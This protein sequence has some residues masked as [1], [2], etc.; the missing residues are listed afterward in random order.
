MDYFPTRPQLAYAWP[1]LAAITPYLVAER[2][3]ELIA[4]LKDAF[5]GTEQTRASTSDDTVPRAVAI[6][7]GAVEVSEASAANPSAPCAIH[8][9]VE[10]AD[11]VYARGL[12]A[13]AASIYEVADQP[14]G[15]RQGAVKDAWGNH[16]YIAKANW[17]PGSEGIS[18]VQ[19]F[20]HLHDAGGIIPFLVAA[21]DAEDLGTACSDDGVVLH[22]TIRIGNAT[23]EID[24]AHET[25][26]PMPCWLHVYVPDVDRAYAQAVSAGATPMEAPQEKRDGERSAAVKDAWGVR[27][28]IATRVT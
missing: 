24:E 11:A 9:Y 21:F 8:L 10:D 7:N 12:Q 4:F 2:A 6:G 1:G 3:A 27:W 5:C 23:L 26:P 15:D 19:P 20:L 22:G 25:F 13:G 28:L 14:W 16:W 17:E 18:T